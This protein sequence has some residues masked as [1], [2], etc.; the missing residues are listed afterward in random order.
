MEKINI[1]NTTLRDYLKPVFR[2]KLVI[3]IT[4]ILGS[5]AT[6][7][8][9]L[10]HTNLY[11]AKV[12][13][14]IKGVPHYESE[15]YR[16]LIAPRIQQTQMAIVTS[17]PVLKRTVMALGL[18]KRPL[19]YEAKFCKPIKVPL[20]KWRAG[21]IKKEL[22][23]LDPEARSQNRFAGAMAGLKNSITTE[24]VGNTEIFE[25]SVKDFSAANAIEIAN[26]L[27]RSYVI[28]DLEQ[29]LVELNMRYGDLH[30]TVQQLQDNIAKMKN[31]LNGKEVSD[32]E[33]IGTAS[34]KII[35]QASSNYIPIGRPKMLIFLAGI[36]IAL[37][38]GFGLALVLD[39]ISNTFNSPDDFTEHLHLPVIGTVPKRVFYNTK[40]IGR[41][42]SSELYESCMSDLA[43][44]T[45]I[46][47]KVQ[48]LKTLLFVSAHPDA[49]SS[50]ITSNLGYYLTERD[51][52]VLVID[53]NITN[54]T[55]NTLLKLE[56]RPGLVDVLTGKMRSIEEA[57]VS[58][59]NNLGFMPVG[60]TKNYAAGIIN[61]RNF[62][63]VLKS[64]ASK[65]E[66][67]IVDCTQTKKI[68]DITMLSTNVDGIVFVANE[69]KDRIQEIKNIINMLGKHK[70]NI[71]GGILYN[72]TFPIPGWLYKKI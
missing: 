69:G 27:S 56:D 13:I 15:T 52:N 39:K 54:P 63:T 43:D 72:R 7:I 5:I 33:A 50:T 64:C 2:H 22:D 29:Q 71:I 42:G 55:I 35:E 59:N 14:Y 66:A 58:Q 37:G 62:K 36:A 61:D 45:F 68:H 26:V 8:A 57:I 17:K 67:I 47:M 12:S 60:T 16:S 19:D 30:P 40:K 20:I 24:I 46:F 11:E 70:G 10:F 28:Y 4:F 44:Q 31:N 18:D 9:L 21:K 25:I 51:I 32:I 38:A 65:Y 3:I 1:K 34:V 48:K 49:S 53:A 41:Y 23:A 6:Y